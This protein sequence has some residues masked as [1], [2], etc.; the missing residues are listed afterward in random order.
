MPPNNSWIYERRDGPSKRYKDRHIP[1]KC[2]R[3]TECYLSLADKADLKACEI[4]LLSS[5]CVIPSLPRHNADNREI[6]ILIVPAK[7]SRYTRAVM[8]SRDLKGSH[9][10]LTHY[11]VPSLGVLLFPAATEGRTP[12]EERTGV[13]L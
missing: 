10:I 12:R 1:I 3:E 5:V 9:V 11:S 13:V 6:T 4:S 2:G 7:K 8:T